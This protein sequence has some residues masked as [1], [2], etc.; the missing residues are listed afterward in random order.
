VQGEINL[1]TLADHKYDLGVNSTAVFW[2]WAVLLTM[3]VTR[4]DILAVS[5]GSSHGCP[6]FDLLGLEDGS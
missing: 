3:N 4:C 6:C 5:R 1:V 2:T